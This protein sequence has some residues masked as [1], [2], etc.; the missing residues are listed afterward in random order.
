[1]EVLEGGPDGGQAVAADDP[2]L[3]APRKQEFQNLFGALIGVRQPGRLGLEGIQGLQSR[4]SL[5]LRGHAVDEFENRT[6]LRTADGFPH[7]VEIQHAGPGQRAVKIKQHRADR[8]FQTP[9][10]HQ[11]HSLNPQEWQTAHPP[12]C[13]ILPPHSGQAPLNRALF[14]IF[15]A[16]PVE[17][18]WF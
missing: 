10:I 16:W 13:S 15:S 6:S 9:G 1:M 14:T 18:R 5:L 11:I 17:A 4:G 2:D 8:L 12:S 3:D 7:H